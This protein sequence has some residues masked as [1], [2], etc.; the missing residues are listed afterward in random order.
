[1]TYFDSDKSHT[2]TYSNWVTD[3]AG[4]EKREKDGIYGN[5]SVNGNKIHYFKYYKNGKFDVTFD[6]H[7]NDLN[8]ARE[9]LG[10]TA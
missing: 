5:H 3:F 8:F 4:Y 6:N 9:Y 2:A 1:L 7:T 10:Y